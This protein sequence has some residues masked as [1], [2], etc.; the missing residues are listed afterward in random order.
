MGDRGTPH[1]RS[2]RQRYARVLKRFA[3]VVLA[4]M[5]EVGPDDVL[6]QAIPVL[7]S[8]NKTCRRN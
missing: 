7:R 4:P 3:R 2:L 8:V 1:Q 6:Y 5:M